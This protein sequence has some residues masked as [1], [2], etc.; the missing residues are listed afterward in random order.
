MKIVITGSLGHIGKPLTEEL[1]RQGHAVT[2]IS[3][4][5]E[6]TKDIEALGAAAAI[7]SV[8]DAAFLA[9]TFAGADSV[10]TMVPPNFAATPDQLGYYKRVAGHYAQAITEAG[11]KRIVNLSSYGAHLDRG[12]GI[13]LGAH[14]A[15]NILNA[16]GGVSIT[17]LRPGYF[18][19]NLYNFS[20]MIKAQGFIGSNYGG[21]DRLMLVAPGD[22]AAVAAEELQATVGA[23]VRYIVSDD[24]SANDVARVLG[25][26]IGKPDLQWMVFTDEQTA[27]GLKGSG[28]PASFVAAFVELGASIHN[29]RLR[30]D[31]DRQG[32]VD[33]GAIKLAE[34]A[35]EFAAAF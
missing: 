22:I 15:E 30:E 10:F 24:R 23:D 28:M 9:N 25:A 13:I 17:H 7:G 5:P 3:S 4:K 27:E 2:V 14:H 16:L 21:E 31:Y 1:V 20:G 32:Q 12:T 33:N 18:Y 26:A 8:E 29:G 19:Y 6:K 35:K 34:F 11:V